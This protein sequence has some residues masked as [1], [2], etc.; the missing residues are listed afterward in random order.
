MGTNH[1]LTTFIF[2]SVIHIYIFSI[3]KWTSGPTALHDMHKLYPDDEPYR[4][5]SPVLGKPIGDFKKHRIELKN[6]LTH[7]LLDLES[8]NKDPPIPAF[9]CYR[10]AF[11]I[12][13]LT[14]KFNEW[15]RMLEDT[16]D[17]NEYGVLNHFFSFCFSGMHL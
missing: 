17:L 2:S 6:W 1:L 16:Q 13:F 9:E 7:Y 15:V 5:E 12:P 8:K 3:F 14:K 10:N 4:P 11:E